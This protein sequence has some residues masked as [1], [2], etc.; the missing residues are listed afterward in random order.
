MST[1]II[2][3]R[4]PHFYSNFSDFNYY[5]FFIKSKQIIVIGRI[6]PESE[7]ENTPNPNPNCSPLFVNCAVRMFKYPKTLKSIKS[8][9]A[10]EKIVLK[11]KP[12]I[13]VLYILLIKEFSLKIND[14]IFIIN[15]RKTLKKYI[16][17]KKVKVASPSMAFLLS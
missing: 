5:S 12:L 3:N 4:A 9:I 13:I 11:N 7:S 17:I 15:P 10:I 2:S 6:N 1:L 8:S 16:N 14:R